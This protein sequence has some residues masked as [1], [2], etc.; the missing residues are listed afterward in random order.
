M[1]LGSGEAG[2]VLGI[3]GDLRC[4]LC[5]QRRRQWREI[6]HHIYVIIIIPLGKGLTLIMILHGAALPDGVIKCLPGTAA[7]LKAALA[8]S[9][10]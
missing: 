5:R 1:Y 3:L 7:L 10:N 8:W 2:P 9:K 4:I 6:A